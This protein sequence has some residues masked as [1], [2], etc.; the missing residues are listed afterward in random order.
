MCVCLDTWLV[1]VVCLFAPY[2]VIQPKRLLAYQKI[3]KVSQS[4]LFE[5]CWSIVSDVAVVLRI[6]EVLRRL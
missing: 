2:G 5:K 6:P 3:L 4:N 1:S